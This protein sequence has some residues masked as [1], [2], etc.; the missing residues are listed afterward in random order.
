M[1]GNLLY[2]LHLFLLPKRSPWQAFTAGGGEH[3]SMSPT[4]PQSRSVSSRVFHFST[5]GPLLSSFKLFAS[6]VILP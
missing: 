5:S 3:M 4:N 6:S 2:T 1:R